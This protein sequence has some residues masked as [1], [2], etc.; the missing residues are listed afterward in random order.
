MGLLSKKV[1][2]DILTRQQE[3]LSK[4]TEQ[5]NAAVSLVTSTIENLKR[6]NEG[7]QEK[8]C[9]IETYQSELARTKGNLNDAKAKNERVIQNF[10]SLLGE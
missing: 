2:K 5:F 6:I 7:I 3:E 9:E 1:S 8:V 10:S 4:Y